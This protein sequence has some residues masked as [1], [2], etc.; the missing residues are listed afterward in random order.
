MELL[1]DMDAATA[2]AKPIAHAHSIWQQIAFIVPEKD[3][4]LWIFSTKLT[5]N[6]ADMSAKPS[7]IH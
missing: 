7:L 5:N 2:A 3:E 6:D 4:L 1:E